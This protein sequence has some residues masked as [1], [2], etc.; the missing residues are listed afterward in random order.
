MTWKGLGSGGCGVTWVWLQQLAVESLLQL[1]QTL[2]D[3]YPTES[4]LNI[5]FTCFP[6]EHESE[7]LH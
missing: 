5:S 2:A 6:L 1:S 7:T 4:I 3:S